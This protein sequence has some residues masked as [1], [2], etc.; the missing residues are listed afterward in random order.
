MA[1][2]RS[3]VGRVDRT[4]V[5]RPTARLIVLDPADRTLLFSSLDEAGK[6]WW[7]TP[8]GGVRRGETLAAAAVRELAEET[9]YV[10][11]EDDLGRVVATCAGVWKEPYEGRRY[12]AADSFFLVRVVDP[13]ISTDG[14][15]ELERSVITGHRWWTVEEL[16]QADG[17]IFPVG[18]AVLVGALLRTGAP[19][20][21]LRL[22]W[23]ATSTGG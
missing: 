6:T 23:R 13:A 18:L 7:F 4:P 10:C 22:E 16:R 12:F 2:T 21:P 3:T 5:W 1:S 11:A 14:Q 9:G 15:E 19:P 8:G 20:H 17:A